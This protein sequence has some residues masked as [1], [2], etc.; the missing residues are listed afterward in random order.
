[1]NTDKRYG[2]E[3][4]VAMGLPLGKGRVAVVSTSSIVANDAVGICEWGADV[5]VA[6]VLEWVRPPDRLKPVIVFDEFHHGFGLHGGSF[7]AV[8]RYLTRTSSGHFLGQAL[9]AGLVLLIALAPRPLPPTDPPRIARRSPL[10]HAD[11]LGHAYADVGATRNL[12]HQLISGVRRRVG[13]TVGVSAGADDGA[14][15]DAVTVR[16]ASLAAPVALIRR[17]L[18]QPISARE[19]PDVG[20]AVRTVEQHLAM[21][22][23]RTP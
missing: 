1:V 20:D 21:P 15:L 13:R 19:V 11:A 17:A 2:P 6:R 7:T 23:Q 18:R 5:A 12:A 22:P 4:A 10:E 3:I 14:F 9:I 16:H 8:T